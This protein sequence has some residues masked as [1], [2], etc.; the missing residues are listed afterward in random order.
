L[1]VLLK[2]AEIEIAVAR[3][4]HPRVNLVVPNVSWG[5]GLHE[6][7]LLVITRAGYAYEVEIK[8]SKS[9]LKKDRE[10]R[11]CHV[12]SRISRLYFAIPKELENCI[13]YVP[14]RAGIISVD[15]YWPNR[16]DV[17]RCEKVREA[18]LIIPIVL[19]KVKN[20]WPLGWVR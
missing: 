9:D 16:D 13:D 14:E 3:Y 15:Y 6:C 2:A 19:V 18:K 4:F 10:K 1:E 20:L 12:S 17:F 8:I 7:D 5:M 11:H